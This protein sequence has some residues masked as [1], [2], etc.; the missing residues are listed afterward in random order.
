MCVQD[1]MLNILYGEASKLEIRACKGC[2][3]ALTLSSHDLKFTG[4]TNTSCSVLSVVFRA[5][6][7]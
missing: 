2:Y 3:M 4:L 1:N 5:V 7:N 6:N